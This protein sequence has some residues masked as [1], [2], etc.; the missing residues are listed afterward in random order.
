[1]SMSNKS[2]KLQPIVN[3][4]EVKD[5]IKKNETAIPNKHK[6]Y[7]RYARKFFELGRVKRVQSFQGMYPTSKT[8]LSDKVYALML[9]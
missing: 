1:M 3:E 4:K 8:C 9:E 5:L 2:S 7:K 6:F